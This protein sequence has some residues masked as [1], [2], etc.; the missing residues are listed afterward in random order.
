[1][2]SVTIAQRLYRGVSVIVG[3]S[4]VMVV[5]SLI[6]TGHIQK[7]WN[8]FERDIMLRYGAV[9]TGRAEIG[10]SIH[11]F[12]NLV[13]R[14]ADYEAKARQHLDALEQAMQAYLS[15]TITDREK[16]EVITIRKGIADYRKAAMEVQRMKQAGQ[17]VAD[18]DK[19]VKGADKSIV[20]AL[21][22]LHQIVLE[23]IRKNSQ[24]MATQIELG[25]RLLLVGLAITILS[26]YFWVQRLALSIRHVL[27][28]AADIAQSV[29][30]GDLSK[31]ITV[32]TE[33]ELGH[34][35]ESMR[36]M[37][38]TLKNF[39]DEQ[40][41]LTEKHT[42]DGTISARLDA[43]RFPGVFGTLAQYTNELMDAQISMLL[44]MT[45]LIQLYVSGTFSE[46]MEALPGEKARI[47][48]ALEDIRTRMMSAFQQNQETIRIKA[49][50]DNASSNVM[51]TNKDG[52]I[53]YLNE[54]AKALMQRCEKDFRKAI[55]NFDASSVI[56]C[57]L[58]LFQKD[59]VEQIHIHAARASSYQTRLELGG[60]IFIVQASSIQN[61]QG[62]SQGI[63][64]EWRDRT[65]EVA[66]EAEIS[67]VVGAASRGDFT[68]RINMN[69]KEGFFLQLAESVNQ[70]VDTSAVG[71][72]D[73]ARVLSALAKGDLTEQITA[74][75]LGTFKQLKDDANLSL[76]QLTEIIINIK[77]STDSINAAA[78][79]IAVG[80]ADLSQRTEEQAANLE[81]TSAS[82]AQL[83]TTVKKNAEHAQ[84]A[85]RLAM[86]AST[87]ATQGGEV[88]KQVV[89]TMS[90]IARA[91]TKMTDIIGVIDGIAFQTNILA[92]NAAVEA[93]RAGEQGRGFAVVAGEVRNLAQRSASAA[94]EIKALISDSSDKVRSGS[95]LVDQAGKTMEEIVTSVKQVTHIMTEISTA[96]IE[97][98]TGIEHVGQ[99]IQQ[100]DDVTQQ[101]AALVEQ[102]AATAHLLEDQARNLDHAVSVFKVR[103]LDSSA[104]LPSLAGNAPH[105]KKPSGKKKGEKV[106]VLVKSADSEDDEWGEF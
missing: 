74:E 15:L 101:N 59:L 100:M 48:N 79:E 3:T 2:S 61:E 60:H 86:S 64:V 43:S 69:H 82:M 55:P 49:A 84:E 42:Q 26:G 92:L 95:A 73:V 16:D 22:N 9:N 99:A 6:K 57:N 80:N 14:G 77:E 102:A 37:T 85:R 39:A 75:Y 76:T 44:R 81:E 24:E 45:D 31:T 87:V 32:T 18:I 88:V 67:N 65:E 5:V 4:I 12:K 90:D 46:Q 21:N 93:A 78:R 68:Q 47:S 23:D 41:L 51:V 104:H 58:N 1:M 52:V 30:E 11:M 98:S 62:Q 27:K 10:E 25:R 71:L 56:S 20:N 96:S 72:G 34:L 13:I 29:A 89:G 91:S 70:V 63:I 103:E 36:S 28:D 19:A 106:K 17:S 97:Q 66:I 50:L 54:A 40:I 53:R 35:L 38:E 33:D 105:S 7:E 8:D 94:K 83:T